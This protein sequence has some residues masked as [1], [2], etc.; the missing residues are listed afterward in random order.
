MY[1]KPEESQ[2]ETSK[3]GV[4]GK[5]SDVKL[6]CRNCSN[7]VCDDAKYIRGFGAS[8]HVCTD[9]S[10]HER[11]QLELKDTRKDAERRD[12]HETLLMLIKC[13]KCSNLWGNVN[14]NKY[15]L[16]PVI[17]IEAFI[18]MS[19]NGIQYKVCDNWQDFPF[20]VEAADDTDMEILSNILDKLYDKMK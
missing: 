11:A 7:F 10:F 13:A 6:A 9:P 3:I 14:P 1:H 20:T 12:E 19:K 5:P 16:V 2:Q 17:N 4:F 15:S 18:V 8:L